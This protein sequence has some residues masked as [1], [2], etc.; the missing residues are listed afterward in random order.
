MKI[1]DVYG[2]DVSRS[3][4]LAQIK[5]KERKRRNKARY[6]RRY[7]RIAEERA[8]KEHPQRFRLMVVP[9][10][11]YDLDS[12]IKIPLKPFLTPE[13]LALDKYNMYKVKIT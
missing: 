2:N 11:I 6:E 10:G 3:V 4:V 8:R 9:P 13:M 5:H 12:P 1:L 7:Y